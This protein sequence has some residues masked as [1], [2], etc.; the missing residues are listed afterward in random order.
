[1]GIKIFTGVI[2]D[3]AC[4]LGALVLIWYPLRGERLEKFQDKILHLHYQKK[5]QLEERLKEIQG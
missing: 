5:Q 2:P 4:L 3:V 1:M